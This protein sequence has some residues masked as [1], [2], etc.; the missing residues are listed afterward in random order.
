MIDQKPTKITL[1]AHGCKHSSELSWDA[2]IVDILDSFYGICISATFHPELILSHMQ[3]WLD[4]K[5]SCMTA[6][7]ENDEEN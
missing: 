1:E 2:G 4:E 6:F 5:K 3:E 7:K